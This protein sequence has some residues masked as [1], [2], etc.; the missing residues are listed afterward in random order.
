MGMVKLCASGWPEFLGRDPADETVPW[1]ETSHIQPFCVQ[2]A[3]R[4]GWAV[5]GGM[6]QGLRGGASA[7]R[8]KAGGLTAG[9]PDLRVYLTMGR[10]VFI[11]Y[12]LMSGSVSDVQERYHE[13]LRGLGHM[14]FVVWARSPADAWLQTKE[15][16]EGV[17]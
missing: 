8:A 6:E 9:E 12:K 2:E 13:M 17:K 16:V 5:A 7:G 1:K 3:R 11:E 10:V 15:I 14:V 4:A